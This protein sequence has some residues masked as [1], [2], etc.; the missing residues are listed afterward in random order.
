MANLSNLAQP[1]ANALFDLAKSSNSIDK[2]LQ[3]LNILS[4][5]AAT[6]DFAN[7]VANP[8]ISKNKILAILLGFLVNPD[9]ILVKF[10]QVLQ[11]NGRLLALPEVWAI[12]EQKVQDERK[13]AKAIIQSAFTLNEAEKAQF[14]QLLTSK[15]GQAVT[16][17]VEVDP[18]LIGGIKIL[19][20]DVVID[21]S[22]KGSLEKMAAQLIR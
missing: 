11:E 22:V 9:D 14:E 10:L 15:F 8:E 7:W 18:N 12:F 2:W 16:A 19:I 5:V 17:T 1:Y 13:A 4:Q 3:H 6:P 21:A 20:N